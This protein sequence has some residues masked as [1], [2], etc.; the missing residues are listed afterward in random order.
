MNTR[1][2]TVES[3]VLWHCSRRYTKGE[4]LTLTAREAFWLKG[5]GKIKP[6]ARKRKAAST[7]EEN[8]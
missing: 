1:T 6:V 2:Y 4:Q 5:Q 8:K 3:D 7:S